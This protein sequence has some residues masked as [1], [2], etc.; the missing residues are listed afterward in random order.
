MARRNDS[1]LTLLVQYPWWVSVVLAGTA[2]VVL[3]FLIPWLTPSIASPILRG[4]LG[5]APLLAPLLALVLLVPTSLAAI[6]AWR[7]RRLLDAQQDLTSIRALS[8]REFE[9]LVAEAY[10]RQGYTVTHIGGDGPDGGVDLTLKKDGNCL[11][12]QCKQWRADKVGVQVVREIFGV[13]TAQRAQGAVIITSGL[14]TQEAKT[15]ASGKPIDLVEGQQLADLVRS[16]QVRP[17]PPPLYAVAG[18]DTAQETGVART[19]AASEPPKANLKTSCP[20]CGAATVLRTAQ[21][22]AHTGER[23]WGCS[24]FPVCRATIPYGH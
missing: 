20:Q 5:G 24:R 17:S 14:F 7:Q 9:A 1:I 16:V 12:V 19:A 3:T 18:A 13:M 22:G 6:R 2:Y 21:R 23:F 10:R 15:F 4:L 8:W 11:I